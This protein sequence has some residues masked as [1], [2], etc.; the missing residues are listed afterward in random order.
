MRIFISYSHCED[1]KG[2]MKRVFEYLNT[3]FQKEEVNG[4]Y[5]DKENFWLDENEIQAGN[6]YDQLIKDGIKNS[7]Y[8]ILFFSNPYLQSTYVRETELPEIIKLCKE[9]GTLNNIIPVRFA[10]TID[11]FWTTAEQKFFLEEKI[12]FAI[13]NKTMYSTAMEFENN[14]TDFVDEIKGRLFPGIPKPK[15]VQPPIITPN[16]EK[17]KNNRF[18]I[19]R[20]SQFNNFKDSILFRLKIMKKPADDKVKSGIL[21]FSGS[22]DQLIN[23]FVLR[24]PRSLGDDLKNENYNFSKLDRTQNLKNHLKDEAR[25]VDEGLSADIAI[26]MIVDRMSTTAQKFLKDESIKTGEKI[27]IP[28]FLWFKDDVSYVIALFDRLK[29]DLHQKVCE[30]D[31]D[32]FTKFESICYFISVIYDDDLKGSSFETTLQSAINSAANKNSIWHISGFDDVS[33][34]DFC[35]WLDLLSE[36]GIDIIPIKNNYQSL[37]ANAKTINM[38][39][40]DDYIINEKYLS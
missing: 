17:I 3:V 2:H 23:N 39:K 13:G 21:F 1:F 19:N 32:V 38:N 9:R 20:E 4:F 27:I 24:I 18:R 37:F 10:K 31:K 35:Y 11:K 5:Y 36:D 40:I 8:F 14:L 34:N 30:G 26:D 16:S 29:T 28:L 12:S 7:E 6:N 22:F 25:I 33:E 15:I